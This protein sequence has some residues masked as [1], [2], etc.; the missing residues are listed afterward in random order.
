MI[1]FWRKITFFFLLWGMGGWGGNIYYLT[2]STDEYCALS[3]SWR[4]YREQYCCAALLHLLLVMTCK[5][6]GD[7]FNWSG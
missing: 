3:A 5:R 4:R 1:E 6:N 7:C 2:V